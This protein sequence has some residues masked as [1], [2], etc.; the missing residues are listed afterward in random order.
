MNLPKVENLDF[1]GKRVLLRAD[2]DVNIAGDDSERLK[3]LIPTLRLLSEKASKIIVMGHRGRPEGKEV[4]ELSL[5]PISDFLEKLLIQEMGKEK[6]DKIDMYMMENLRFNKGEE[7][8]DKHFAKHLA[9]EGD[10]YVNEAFAASHRKHASIVSLPK[11][12]PSAAGIH[13]PQEVENLS[14][15]LNNPQKPVIVIIGGA[16]KD[17]LNYIEGFKKI[18][19][20]ILIGGRLPDYLP[21]DFKDPKVLPARL[22]A[23]KEDITVNSIDQFDQ[24]IKKAGTIIVA[25]PMGK[26]EEE[27]HRL[28]TERVFKAIT[29]TKALKIAGGGDT[30]KAISILGLKDKFDWIS[31]GG[32][33]S[34]EF[35]IK[36]TLPGIEALLN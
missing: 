35:L 33:A 12:L 8:N 28:G 10:V 29:E 26:F 31:V 11:M 36:G 18:A 6:V 16:K 7:E 2:L 3:I 4:K 15:V 27:G 9:E 20:K 24:E 23:D 19:D 32:G 13:F 25:G 14:K 22:I 17:K 30:Q 21:E 1:Q 5:K 34:L